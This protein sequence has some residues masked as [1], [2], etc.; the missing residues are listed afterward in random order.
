MASLTAMQTDLRKGG[1]SVAEHQLLTL[2]RA[3]IG[4]R[5]A[6]GDSFST[7]GTALDDL[8]SITDDLAILHNRN[9]HPSVVKSRALD[10]AVAAYQ[11][12]YEIE[13]GLIKL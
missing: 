1:A 2:L 9:H 8:D 7:F 4:I 6:E 11:L 5:L 3:K 12:A 13:T 10:L